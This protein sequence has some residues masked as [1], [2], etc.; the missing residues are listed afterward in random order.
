MKKMLMMITL[1]LLVALSAAC[2]G[3]EEY[4]AA[5][6]DENVDKCEVCNMQVK[7]NPF[8]TQIQ[9]KDKKILKFDDLG[10]L[11]VWKQKNGTDQIGAQF[12]RDYNTKEW[13]HLEDATYVYDK[14]IR[15]PMAF[16]VISFQKKEDAEKF[17]SEHGSG[18]MMSSAELDQHKWEAD[19]DMMKEM[20]GGHKHDENGDSAHGEDSDNGKTHNEDQEHMGHDETQGQQEHK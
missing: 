1:S 15:T 9:L 4:K 19:P 18:R 8:A 16:G 5:D 2:G 13:M 12:V 20:H 7:D 14:G 10:D 6:I 3:K 17:V 11:F